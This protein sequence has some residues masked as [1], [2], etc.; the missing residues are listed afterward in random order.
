MLTVKGSRA[1]SALSSRL[2]D[3]TLPQVEGSVIETTFRAR[4]N[5]SYN[6]LSSSTADDLRAG[7]Q[8]SRAS[9]TNTVHQV[10][11]TSSVSAQQSTVEHASDSSNLIRPLERSHEI[12]KTSTS[13]AVRRS[14]SDLGRADD[15]PSSSSSSDLDPVA[16]PS[17]GQ[18]HARRSRYTKSRPPLAPLSDAD[19]DQEDSRP[20]LP[21]SDVRVF[22]PTQRT[23]A[24]TS[25]RN[26][27]ETFRP[28]SGR[29]APSLLPNQ[30]AP[31]TQTS[32]SSSSSTQSQPQRQP[33]SARSAQNPVSSLSPRQRRITKEGSEG[34]PSMGSSFSDLD[35]AS[36]TQ[37]ALEEALANEMNRG[38]VASRM[39]TI[40]QALRSRYL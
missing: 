35:D 29:P 17:R 30:K 22:T 19:E 28:S 6:L 38:G 33:Q 5:T 32:Q 31:T 34:T 26:N 39:S 15:S 12:T 14:A 4:G 20:F 25:A 1:P 18:V 24:I 7:P 8:L 11:K 23:E 40:S 27:D 37:S 3:R 13:Q 36:V 21:F 9:S 16:P 2:R 10:P